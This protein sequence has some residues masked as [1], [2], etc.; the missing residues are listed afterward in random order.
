MVFGKLREWLMMMIK[1]IKS[2]GI[3]IFEVFLIF[4][5]ILRDIMKIFNRIKAVWV[6]RVMVGFEMIEVNNWV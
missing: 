3:M 1:M 5:W 6:F 4:F 2:R